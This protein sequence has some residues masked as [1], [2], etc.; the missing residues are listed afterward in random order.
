M[1]S[2]K[3]IY[4]YLSAL[5]R[6]AA[7]VILL[8]W[9]GVVLAAAATGLLCLL[10]LTPSIPT[11]GTPRLF[12]LGLLGVA[13][14]VAAAMLVQG[15]R[16]LRTPENLARLVG[17]RRPGL[18]SD[19]LSTVE[20]EQS[21]PDPRAP[22]S[23]AIFA[24]LA[25][26]TAHQL[27][28]TPP[29]IH[30]PLAAVRP[31]AILLSVACILWAAAATLAPAR[32][33][34]GA[35][36]LL[37]PATTAQR[38]REASEPLVG[39]LALTYRFPA[40]TGLPVR[41][42]S[43]STGQIS[44]PRGTRITFE[45]SALVPIT[46]A[47]LLLS[48]DD[49]PKPSRLALSL[50]SR[51]RISGSFLVQ[52][53]GSYRF[54]LQPPG[55][56][57]VLDPVERRIA[58]EADNFPRL[59]LYGPDNDLEVTDQTLVELGFIAEDDYGLREVR[60][61][62]QMS[63]GKVQRLTLWK[64]TG[65]A[66]A[67]SAMGKETWDLARVDLRPGARLAYWLEALD[68]DTVSGPKVAQTRPRSLRVHSPDQKHQAA[69]AL[70]TRA[71]EQAIPVL[72][73]RLLLFAKDP[74]LSANLRYDKAV[75]VHRAQGQLGDILR[76]LTNRLDKDLLATPALRRTVNGILG[77]LTLQTRAEARLIRAAATGRRKQQLKEPGLKILRQGNDRLVA[78]MER[79]VLSLADMLDEQR[80]QDLTRLAE[81]LR[82][83][84]DQL[85]DL[86]ARYRKTPTEQ[87]KQQILRLIR[88]LEALSAKM[89]A[90]AAAMEGALPDEYLNAEAMGKLEVRKQLRD[91]ADQIS[92]GKLD[93]LDSAM[94]A[95]DRDLDKLQSMLG[96]G[97]SKFRQGRMAEQE[98]RYDKALDDLRDLEQAQRKVAG[99]TAKVIKRYRERAAQ[100]MKK[101]IQPFIRKQ[102]AR[103]V[104]LQKK[105][106]EID[107]D[108]L[109]A[110][111]QEQL[112]RVHQ[113]I[114]ELEGLLGAADLNE[115]LRMARRARNGLRLLEDDLSEELED[116]YALRRRK[117]RRAHQQSRGARRL[118]DEIVADLESIFPS[119]S[120]M[121][122]DEDRKATRQL[123]QRQ[124]ELQRKAQELGAR[125]GKSGH[126]APFVS[127]ELLKSLKES[128]GQMGRSRSTLRGLKLQEA[129]GHQEAAAD[130][131]ARAQKQAKGARSP[132]RTKGGQ[133]GGPRERVKIPDASAFRPPREFRKDIME[134]MKEKTPATFEQL[135][136]RYYEELVR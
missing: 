129:R 126:A 50:P 69:L 58:V 63:G 83:G 120:S 117:V 135:V 33:A 4:S 28:A 54:S 109:S 59:T 122:G 131:L 73:D 51:T 19:L 47:A 121:L 95:L 66:P 10:L 9:G 103:L 5:G 114:S 128:S 130:A 134:A 34:L 89:M 2:T 125:L 94:A 91:L 77:R 92:Q 27:R 102:Q 48:R 65:S 70:M 21:P 110:Y 111:D 112:Q 30:A 108:T 56:E 57:P 16:R 76:E 25:A 1:H 62:Y 86:L 67:R 107:G 81:E 43:S 31:A 79:D 123:G 127:P 124:S 23:P 105:V 12:P 113:R 6:R 90:R 100:L 44:A 7:L 37:N 74:P 99:E 78:E 106:K 26:R 14:M 29:A 104:E 119:P 22:F 36:L 13:V 118:A 93:D 132:Q 55:G 71:L 32:L 40:Y 61:A 85:K 20:L 18:L 11:A 133:S 96:G 72:G 64:P 17:R 46:G 60:L 97:V 87:L 101:T 15:I 75:E 24:A 35:G 52:G 115:S 8:R 53:P 68:N 84:R 82:R 45:T 42:V 39:D 3:D 116:P 41:H 38:Q 98:K 80:L 49:Q 88:Q 136:R